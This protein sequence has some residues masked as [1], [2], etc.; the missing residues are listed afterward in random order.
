MKNKTTTKPSAPSATVAAA[1]AVATGANSDLGHSPDALAQRRAELLAL[2]AQA[3]PEL[4]SDNQLDVARL[5]DLLGEDHLTRP[6]HYELNWAGKAAARREIQKTSSHTL[7]PDTSNPTQAQHMLIEGENLEVLRV[8]QKSYY[9]K[10]KMIY[11]DPPYNTGNDS[12]VYPDDYSETL[13]EY[14]R[15]T[16]EKNEAGFLNKQSLWKKNSKESGQYHSAWLSMMYPRLYLARNLLRDDGVIFISIDD[17]EAANLKVLCDE[18]FG[19]ENFLTQF[20]W[21]TEGHT[22]N[23]FEVKINHE[24]VLL[25]SKK[26]TVSKLGYVIDPNTRAESNLWKGFAEN[27]ITKNG[28]ANPPSI[29]V[30]PIGFPCAAQEIS[31]QS[32]KPS[33]IFFKDLKS[34]GFISRDMTVRSEISYPIRLDAMQVVSGQ[35]VKTCKVF[36]GWANVHKLRE[37]IEN[38]CEPIEDKSDKIS[39]FL[40]ENGVIYYRRDREK[41]RNIVSVLRNFGTTEKMRSEL[42]TVGLSFQYPKPKDLLKYLLRTG[43]ENDEVIMDFFAGSGTTAH[44]V[45]ELN[46]EDGGNRQSI[47]VQMP[48]VLDED[49]EA[50]KAGYRTI[51]DITRARIS[52][53]ISKLKAEHPDKTTDLA[54]AH[55]NLAPSNFK[56]WRGDANNVEALREQLALF[57]SAEK[58]DPSTGSG[59]TGVGS[60]RTVEAATAMLAELLLKHGLGAL[61]V[62]AISQPKQ[63]AGVTVHRV[64]LPTDNNADKTMWL[65]FDPYNPAL[66]EEIVKA[67]PA[68]VVMLNSCFAGPK[69]DE[70]LSNLQLELAA[71]EIALTVI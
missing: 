52:K 23:Q 27:S 22:D 45:M 15:R 71:F 17:N 69:A 18:V 26:S 49:S 51:A 34:N 14:Q 33:N 13:G 35:L 38:G 10:V 64:R 9:G 20:V 65:C 70:L 8:L 5:Q 55:F 53:V 36:S 58:D 67:K 4:I 12:F 3:A 50:Y 63:V 54:C 19:A 29:V 62:H 30:L 21:N 56:V 40:S 1:A 32:N 44:A 28:P 59:R 61:G 46:L 68:Q 48:E 47:S 37:F 60:G 42:E 16:G 25:Y 41:A 24:Y 39:F 2:L 43:C 7:R 11:I 6:E 31:F 66:K 57:Q